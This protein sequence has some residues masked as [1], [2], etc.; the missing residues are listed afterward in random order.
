MGGLDDAYF[1]SM[2]S[3]LA[4]VPDRIRELFVSQVVNPQGLFAVKLIQDGVMQEVLVDSYIPIQQHGEL[5]FSRTNGP[6]LWVIILEKAYAKLKGD[7]ASIGSG[8]KPEH[9]ISDLTGAPWLK[10]Y[11]KEVDGDDLF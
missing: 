2:L 5:Q 1:L 8:G 7:Y 3:G 9:A 4:E 11:T 6:E 10:L